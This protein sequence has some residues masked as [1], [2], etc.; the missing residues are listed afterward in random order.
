MIT[1]M[2]HIIVT[3]QPVDEKLAKNSSTRVPVRRKK[4]WKTRNWES[5]VATIITSTSTESMARSV[6]TVPKALGN[7]TPSHRRRMP[8]RANSPTRGI[9]RLTA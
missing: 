6:T 4:D 1:A 3:S 7:E 8:Q 2:P 5:S 9:S